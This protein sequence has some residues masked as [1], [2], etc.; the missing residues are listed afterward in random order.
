L[1]NVSFREGDATEMVFGKIAAAANLGIAD[2]DLLRN[3]PRTVSELSRECGVLERTLY[4]L[5]R[6][7]SREFSCAARTVM[8]ESMIT[9]GRYAVGTE[10]VSFLVLAA[11]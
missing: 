4:R 7:L 10:V 1:R 3:G 9:E 8:D 2:A 5:L 11:R 6:A